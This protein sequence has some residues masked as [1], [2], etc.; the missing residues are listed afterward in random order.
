MKNDNDVSIAELKS[1]LMDFSK[2]R[3]WD[4]RQIPQQ[5]AKALVI[6]SSE[7]LQEFQWINDRESC[8]TKRDSKK[9]KKITNELVDILY[10]LVTIFDFY[11][12]DIT[13]SVHTKLR[14]LARRYKVT[15]TS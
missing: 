7:L 9:R 11:K 5:L 10:Y 12:L 13:S 14:L 4:K 2:K 3:G 6:E 8:R 1:I 15:K